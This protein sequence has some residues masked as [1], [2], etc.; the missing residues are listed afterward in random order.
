[1]VWQNDRTGNPESAE[2]AVTPEPAET[3]SGEEGPDEAE[4]LRDRW[5]RAAAELDNLRKRMDRE[6][7]QA[8]RQERAAVVGAFLE[9]VDNLDRALSH[10]SAEAPGPWIE[11]WEAL[12]RQA[13]QTLKRCGV[14]PFEALG[15]QFDPRR[16]QAV[17]TVEAPG[18]E[19]G[20]I[21]EVVL[22]G[23]QWED[24]SILRHAKVV[25]ARGG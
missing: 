20:E 24:G 17:A 7:T 15:E 1:M 4:V 18:R 10:A 21:V 9:I 6:L 16:H 13:R 12:V 2:T 22:P 5:L 11:G 8:R 3:S 14:E 23:Y 19:E 25:A